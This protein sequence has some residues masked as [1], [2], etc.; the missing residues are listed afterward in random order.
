MAGNDLREGGT[1]PPWEEFISQCCVID[2]HCETEGLDPTGRLKSGWLKIYGRRFPVWVEEEVASWHKGGASEIKLTSP[3]WE[4]MTF[5]PDVSVDKTGEDV[6]NVGDP[7][8]AFLV[9]RDSYPADTKNSHYLILKEIPQRENVFVR[10]GSLYDHSDDA[11]LL[12]QEELM[13]EEEITL[14]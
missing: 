8:Y 3:G 6:I 2:Y 5:S 7:L 10:V 14:I 11:H 12:L 13:I 1:P 4:G 9:G